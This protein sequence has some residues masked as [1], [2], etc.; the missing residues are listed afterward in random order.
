[1]GDK[2]EDYA[3]SGI[4]ALKRAA[5]RAMAEAKRRNL[6][7]PIWKDGTVEYISPETDTGQNA[8]PNRYSTAFHRGR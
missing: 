2:I 4:T 6:K 7:V 3:E 8:A 1:M 5:S